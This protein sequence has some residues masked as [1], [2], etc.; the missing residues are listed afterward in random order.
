MGQRL[1]RLERPFSVLLG[2][3]LIISFEA[4]ELFDR[5]PTLSRN[6]RHT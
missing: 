1:G 2:S 5:A 6:A 3:D 4:I